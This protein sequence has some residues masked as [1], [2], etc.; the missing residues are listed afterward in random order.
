MFLSRQMFKYSLNQR[1]TQLPRATIILS[2][3][4]QARERGEE[5]VYFSEQERNT[6]K[7]I[8]ARLDQNAEAERQKLN[9]MFQE[10]HFFVPTSEKR[11]LAAARELDEGLVQ[12][13]HEYGVK[14]DKNLM[15]SLKAWKTKN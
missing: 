4:L 14:E 12:I 2:S 10:D 7:R 8:I 5:R 13:F 6:M 11:K 15:K 1:I 3:H 9:Q